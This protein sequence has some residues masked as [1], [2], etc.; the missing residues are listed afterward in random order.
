MEVGG[1]VVGWRWGEVEWWGG[2]GGG[3]EWWGGGGDG[4]VGVEV[5][6]LTLLYETLYIGI[7]YL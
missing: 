6:D 2:G 7:M 1:G 5:G 4:V 3:V